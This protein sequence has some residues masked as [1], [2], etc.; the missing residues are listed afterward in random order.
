MLSLYCLVVL[1]PRREYGSLNKSQEAKIKAASYQEE[2]L[3]V[4]I[5]LSETSGTFKKYLKTLLYLA[6]L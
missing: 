5:K 4:E 2:Q 3:T 1:K 6:Y